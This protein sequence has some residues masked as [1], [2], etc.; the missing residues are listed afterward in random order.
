MTQVRKVLEIERCA[1]DLASRTHCEDE[2]CFLRGLCRADDRLGGEGVHVHD[3]RV[4]TI[5]DRL[6]I[7]L[8]RLGRRPILDD[9]ELDVCRPREKAI[10][11]KSRRVKG[12][13]TRTRFAEKALTVPVGNLECR[14]KNRHRRRK[15]P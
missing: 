14:A 10:S 3:S 2:I 6:E 1:K 13:E 8:Q 15:S 9:L 7:P 4:A 12:P 5:D 11:Q